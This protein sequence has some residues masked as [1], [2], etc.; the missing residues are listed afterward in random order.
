[1][2]KENE[3]QQSW[4]T[5]SRPGY[6]GK[7]K[8]IQY[9]AWDKEFG[10]GNWQIAW[11]LSSGEI[12]GFDQ[13]FQLYVDGYVL[14][15]ENHLEEAMFLTDNYSY[16]YDKDL[17]S[18]EEAFNPYALVNVPGRPNQF[19]N[20]ALNIALEFYLHM[21]FKGAEPIQIREGKPNTDPSTWPAGWQWGPG[22][23]PSVHPELIP[24]SSLTSWWQR[25]SIEDLYQSAKILQI[26]K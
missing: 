19:H 4:K 18:K 13:I 6:L 21:E 2:N 24:E 22:R 7:N 1:M 3:N 8:E 16:G 5:V 25:G 11:Q 12:L 26:K 20:V 23:I 9:A 10:Q 17:V 15:F 14:Y